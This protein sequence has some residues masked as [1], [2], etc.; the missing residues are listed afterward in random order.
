MVIGLAKMSLST[1]HVL[2]SLFSCDPQ[3]A[4]SITV[5]F[6]NNPV[7]FNNEKDSAYLANLKSRSVSPE[8]GG[9]FPI[10]DGMMD[11]SFQIEHS[12]NFS[13]TIRPFMRTAC[14]G[15]SDINITL[16]YAATI[17]VD[18]RYPPGTC[19]YEL[20]KDH[21]N[22]HVNTDVSTINE[23]IPYIQKLV[24]A[25]ISQWPYNG[26]VAEDQ[27][28]KAEKIMSK[29]IDDVLNGAT[30]SLQRARNLRQPLVD[31]HEEYVRVSK[32]CPQEN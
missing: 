19:R 7:Q 18:K 20:T 27:L 2:A 21:E 11:S 15:V 12:V 31:S 28:E 3:Q 22:K 9:E 32:A 29:E 10:V 14:A 16:I 4:P 17:Y 1:G 13:S 25:K 8:Y 23:Y 26:Q 6:Q 5:N 24:Q 30:D